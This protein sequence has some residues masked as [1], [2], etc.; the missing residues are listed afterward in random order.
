MLLNDWFL[1]KICRLRTQAVRIFCL[2]LGPVSFNASSLFLRPLH[3]VS[4]GCGYCPSQ[5]V[6]SMTSLLLSA[7]RRLEGG[8]LSGQLNL[9]SSVIGSGCSFVSRDVLLVQDGEGW[10][11][12]A[13]AVSA[14]LLLEVGP[15]SSSSELLFL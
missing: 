3:S 7:G 14:V 2:V 8:G 9:L 5:D 12:F 13:S 10:L 6:G 1:S 4:L 15:Q 11:F